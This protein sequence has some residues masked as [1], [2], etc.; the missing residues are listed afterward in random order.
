MLMKKK[1]LVTG[2]N[3]FVGSNLVR[4]LLENGYEVTCMVRRTSNLS[5]IENLPVTFKYADYNSISSLQEACKGQDIIF[6]IAA[7]VREI[8]EKRYF[9]ANVEVT[10]NLL[11]SI[12]GSNIEKFVFLSTQAAAGPADGLIPKTENCDCNPVSYYGKSKLEAERVVREECPVPWV[13]IRP[14][15]VYG[16]Y[17]KDF[18]QYFELVNKHL[19]PLA[20]FKKKYFSLVY[21]EDLVQMI[22]LASENEHANNE[23]FFAGDGNIYLLENFIDAV[24][25]AMNK[26]AI[27]LH[28]PIFLSYI[29]AAFNECMKYFTKKQAT[30]NLQKVKEMKQCYWL[31]SI[32]KAQNMLNYKPHF[33]LKEGVSETYQWYKEHRWL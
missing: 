2:A 4:A 12:K 31:C 26:N 8:N 29:L 9:D 17:D 15:S 23:I 28:I 19:A 1:V 3:G 24:K 20:G 21:V 16:P 25:K 5:S 18:L 10:R 22:I 7:K 32:E 13:I 30:I 33:S 6:H 27:N 11:E 14:P